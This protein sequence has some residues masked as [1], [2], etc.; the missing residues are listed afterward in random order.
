MVIA[1]PT[2][3][4]VFNWIATMWGGSVH[5]TVPMQFAIGF[6]VLFVLGA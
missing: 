1:I 3:I 4:K 2:G 5:F 6:L